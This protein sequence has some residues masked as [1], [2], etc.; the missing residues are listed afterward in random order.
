MSG[1]FERIQAQRADDERIRR[2]H[3]PIRR[4]DEWRRVVH[5]L[6]YEP[7]RMDTWGE[8]MCREDIEDM[9]HRFA[10]L[11]HDQVIDTNHDNISNES[12]VVESYIVRAPDPDFSIGSWVAGVKVPNDHIWRQI[13]IG[14]INSF[15]FESMVRRVDC[16]VWIDS[17]RDVVCKT[18]LQLDHDHTLFVI[19]NE[20]GIV[21]RGWTDSVDDHSH[22][23][24]CASRTELAGSPKHRHRFHL[25][26]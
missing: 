9:C 17:V 8:F 22:K 1:L 24:V 16:R 23:V 26:G 20:M 15:S 25:G 4:I 10:E 19:T 18:E 7:D 21:Q 11:P 5:G 14:E 13:L 3:V 12:Y 6:V 2:C